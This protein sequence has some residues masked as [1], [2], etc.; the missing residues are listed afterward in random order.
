MFE[1]KKK[2]TVDYEVLNSSLMRMDLAAARNLIDLG[3]REIYD[4]QGR[5]PEALFEDARRKNANIPD[6]RMR[7]F[8]VAVYFSECD[9][10]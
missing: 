7:Y 2:K 8:R 3:I 4:L 5:V 6:H 9:A 1:P 10:P